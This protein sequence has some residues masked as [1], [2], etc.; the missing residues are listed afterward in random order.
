MNNTKLSPPWYNYVCE[1]KELFGPDPDIQIQFN[2]NKMDLV[3]RVIGDDKAKAIGD[4]LPLAKPFGDI[5]L[6][7]S[8]IPANEPNAT[9]KYKLF[10]DA[11]KGNPAVTNIVNVDDVFTNPVTYV[12]F[13][14]KVIQYFNDDMSDLHGNRT[15]LLEDIAKEVFEYND[16]GVFFCTEATEE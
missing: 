8:V 4:L 2:P 9:S 11:F 6:S 15:T 1:I 14:K 5:S 3:L 16:D 7:I 12:E 13:Q 10:S